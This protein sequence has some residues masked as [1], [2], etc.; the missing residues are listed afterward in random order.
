MGDYDLAT[1][2]FGVSEKKEKKFT[3]KLKLKCEIDF[4][5]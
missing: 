5:C 3:T 1:V 4:Q 2:D